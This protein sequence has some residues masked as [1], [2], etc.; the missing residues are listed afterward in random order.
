[1]KATEVF[2]GGDYAYYY[3]WTGRARMALPLNAKKVR[4]VKV[5]RETA[6]YSERGTM[7]AKLDD[8]TSVQVRHLIDEW[9]AYEEEIAERK[10]TIE[11]R[12][13]EEKERRQREVFEKEEMAGLL[14]ELGIED[15]R[16]N[17]SYRTVSITYDDLR[18]LVTRLNPPGGSESYARED[19]EIAE[20]KKL[21]GW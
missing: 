4:V 18:N 1:M 12:E 6:Y 14:G 10:A 16:I 11:R 21:G 5:Y 13:R 9:D 7:Y 19:N 8:G 2:S 20:I 15:V 17:T 3:G